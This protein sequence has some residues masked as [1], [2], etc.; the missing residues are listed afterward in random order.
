[1]ASDPAE[2]SCVAGVIELT[3]TINATKDN[4]ARNN[5]I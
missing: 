4:I 2:G 5:F 3:T 1:M